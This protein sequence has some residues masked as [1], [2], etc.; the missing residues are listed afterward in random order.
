MAVNTSRSMNAEL[1]QGVID[2]GYIQLCPN[3]STE[4]NPQ[5]ERLA[6]PT[7]QQAER[8]TENSTQKVPSIDNSIVTQARHRAE[9]DLRSH[10]GAA[11]RPTQVNTGIYNSSVRR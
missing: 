5:D 9:G 11:V 7:Y 2:G 3:W 6:W 8:H 1:Q 10:P 4:A